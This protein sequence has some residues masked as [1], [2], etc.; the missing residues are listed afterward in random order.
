MRVLLLLPTTT[1]R[2]QAFMEAAERLGIEVVAASEKASTLADKNPSGLMTLDFLNPEASARTVRQFS[3]KF[4][5]NAVIPVD[6]DTAVVAAAIGKELSL[7]HNSIEAAYAARNKHRMRQLLHD[8]NAPIP[9]F[10]LFSF[11]D[12]LE[13]I[14]HSVKYPCVLKPLF[15]SASRGVIR[16]DNPQEFVDAFCRLEN[17]LQEPELIERGRE[18]SRQFLVEQFIPGDEVALE[19]LMVNGELQVL[20]LFDKPDPLDGPYFAETIY[21]T[22]SRISAELQSEIVKVTAKAAKA[23]GLREGP[24]H[25]ELRINDQGVW[26]LE[27]AARSIGGLCS[28]TLRFG[29]GI[30]LEDLILRHALGLELDSMERERQPAGVMMIPVPRA[31][32]F[33]AINGLDDA[34]AVPCI[35]E[36][37]ITAHFKQQVRPLPEGSIYLGF[38]FS[39][40]E[41]PEQVE[42]ALREAYSRLEFD[43]N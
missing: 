19:G 21:V 13:E 36:V 17:L 28:R 4:P 11:N 38:I 27:I 8:A 1:Y 43:I 20:A 29:A 12:E 40:A 32:T 22:P 30:A 5:I 7:P 16:A 15:L 26:I 41:T 42:A 35:E 39:R 9:D 10:Q 2:T 6:E 3:K 24:V 37:K 14:A 23:L 18:A 31:G 33:K 25:A 34:R